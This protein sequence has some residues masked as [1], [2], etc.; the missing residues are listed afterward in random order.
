MVGTM[1]MGDAVMVDSTGVEV[2]VGRIAVGVTV[3][4]M[5]VEVGRTMEAIGV[6]VKGIEVGVGGAGDTVETNEGIADGVS[7]GITVNGVKEK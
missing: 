6:A 5:S 3:F 4:G 2:T 1:G 7:V